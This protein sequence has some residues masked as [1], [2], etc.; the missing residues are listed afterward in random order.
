MTSRRAVPDHR[1]RAAYR[2]AHHRTA[3][4]T[5]DGTRSYGGSVRH[6]LHQGTDQQQRH[7][8][9]P[10]VRRKPGLTVLPIR[11]SLGSTPVGGASSKIN[12]SCSVRYRNLVVTALVLLSILVACAPPPQPVPPAPIPA[13]PRRSLCA[14]CS[15]MRGV[16]SGTGCTSAAGQPRQATT[17]G[18]ITIC[19]S[20]APQIRGG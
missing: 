3:V 2:R 13:T 9:L 19:T 11:G 20:S 1:R 16:G 17:A 12:V 5:R 15:T 7:D 18:R 6:D 8:H 4:S 10:A 14:A